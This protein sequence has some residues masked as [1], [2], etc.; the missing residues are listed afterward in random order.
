MPLCKCAGRPNR[1]QASLAATSL[2]AVQGVIWRDI[3]EED[4]VAPMFRRFQHRLRQGPGDVPR[5]VVNRA[6]VE[7]L[8]P[9]VFRRSPRKRL[10]IAGN[11]H[12]GPPG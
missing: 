5:I 1:W 11:D 2:I 3:G 8:P 10:H 4:D 7:P 12:R 6:I 9:F